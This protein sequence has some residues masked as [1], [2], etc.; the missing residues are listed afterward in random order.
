MNGE[1]VVKII[2]SKLI[3]KIL[4]INFKIPRKKEKINKKRL[5]I[6]FDPIYSKKKININF[7][8]KCY[9]FN[10]SQ[11]GNILI[12]NFLKMIRFL[13]IFLKIENF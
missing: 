11:K 5:Y 4:N 6:K 3:Q 10:L 1:K 8:K 9:C 13:K 7:K 12:V 2:L